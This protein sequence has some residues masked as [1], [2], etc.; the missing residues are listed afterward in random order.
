MTSAPYALGVFR[1]RA[2][3]APGR[4]AG[5]GAEF[6]GLVAGGLVRDISGLG[7]MNELLDHWDCAQS[8]LDELAATVPTTDP[9]RPR[10]G[11]GPR[12]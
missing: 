6:T 4:P 3:P 1:R 2:T 11:P 12:T 9:P 8:R 7:T 10:S 5:Y